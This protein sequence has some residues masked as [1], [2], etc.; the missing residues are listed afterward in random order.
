MIEPLTIAPIRA[1]WG[2]IRAEV[3]SENVRIGALLSE[4]YP[5][6]LRGDTVILAVPYPFHAKK[7]NSDDT[8]PGVEEAISRVIGVPLKLRCIVTRAYISHQA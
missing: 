8:R 5:V 1:Q 3:T 4:M 7:V 2:E 6:E